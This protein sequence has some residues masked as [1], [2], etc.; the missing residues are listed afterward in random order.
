MYVVGSP[1]SFIT[2]S[3]TKAKL[4]PSNASKYFPWSLNGLFNSTN[5]INKLLKFSEYY[6][7]E[8]RI[9]MARFTKL[10]LCSLN[11]N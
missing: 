7:P 2:A 5:S 10:L 4:V 3:T 1:P 11:N 9:Y 6:Y 8:S